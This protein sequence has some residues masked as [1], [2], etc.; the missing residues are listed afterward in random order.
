MSDNTKKW[1]ISKKN[2]FLVVDEKENAI[3]SVAIRSTNVDSEELEKEQIRNINLIVTAPELLETLRNY[4][5][6]L[7]YGPIPKELYIEAY[8]VIHKAVGREH[9]INE[10]THAFCV[11]CNELLPPY[12]HDA[13]CESCDIKNEYRRLNEIKEELLAI[14]K[15]ENE[16]SKLHSGHEGKYQSII[17]KLV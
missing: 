15:A 3:A 2:K 11:Q 7:Q 14:V 4:V 6:Q 5:F 8:R 9:E 1:L 16:H 10:Y 17:D 12:G 13:T